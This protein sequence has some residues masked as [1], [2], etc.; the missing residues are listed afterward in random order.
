MKIMLKIM[1]NESNF[2]SKGAESEDEE[3]EK[4]RTLTVMSM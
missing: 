1:L 4:K 2:E 3:E